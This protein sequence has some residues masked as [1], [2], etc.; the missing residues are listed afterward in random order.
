[1]RINFSQLKTLS[2]QTKSGIVLG[3]V[4]DLVLEIEGQTILQYEVGGLVGK[5]YFIN[6]EQV[7][8]IDEEKMI[9]EDSVVGVVSDEGGVKGEVMVEPGGAVMDQSL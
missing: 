1:M 8:N 9:V 4:K 3:K 5:K 2:V 6:R 7:L